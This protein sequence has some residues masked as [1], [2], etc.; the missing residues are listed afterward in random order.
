[1]VDLLLAAS[2][3]CTDGMDSAA[4][5]AACLKELACRLRRARRE[6]G[7]AQDEGAGQQQG[8]EQ[9]EKYGSLLRLALG[10]SVPVDTR[11]AG[12]WALTALTE[13]ARR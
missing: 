1:L 13:S 7:T 10:S 9:E 3:D 4:G 2:R 6:G 5:I 8:Q 12:L 11:V